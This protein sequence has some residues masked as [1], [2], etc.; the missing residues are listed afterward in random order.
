MTTVMPKGDRIKNAVK[1][2]SEQ[3]QA[4]PGK[5]PTAIADEATLKFDLSP[6]EAEFLLKFVR[7][8]VQV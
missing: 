2:V 5:A 6:T 7:G 3:R 1:W 4:D 8:E